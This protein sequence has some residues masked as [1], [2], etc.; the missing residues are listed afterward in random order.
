MKT[1]VATLAAVLSLG[2][3]EPGL[4]SVQA[5]DIPWQKAEGLPAGVLVAHVTGDAKGGPAVDY[6]KFPAGVRVPLH[7][8]SANHVVTVIS[9]RLHIGGPGSPELEKGFEVGPG[10][11]YKIPAKTPHWTAAKDVTVIAVSGDAP[12]DLHWVKP[13]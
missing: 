7:W 6:I 13:D 8:H 3:Q 4:V 9:G 1:L 12:N 5:G 10:G 2:P 11:Y